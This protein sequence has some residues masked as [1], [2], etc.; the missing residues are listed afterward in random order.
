MQNVETDKR[1]REWLW[2]KRRSRRKL[3]PA[4]DSELAHVNARYM[5]FVSGPEMQGRAWLDV[6]KEKE[7]KFHVA[8]GPPLTYREQALHIWL[9]TLYPP[10]L[11]IRDPEF[12]AEFSEFSMVAVDDDGYPL[13]YQRAKT[14]VRADASVS[15]AGDSAPAEE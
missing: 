14:P 2:R 12:A 5:A 1:R 6:L 9:S 3:S 13:H 8:D 4:E 11:E 10:K 15:P 7:R